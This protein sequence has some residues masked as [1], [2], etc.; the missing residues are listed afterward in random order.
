MRP[1]PPEVNLL[2]RLIGYLSPRAALKRRWARF[3]LGQIEMASGRYRG[4]AKD[5]LRNDWITT[6]LGSS[7]PN[8]WELEELRNR[9]RELNCNHPVAHGATDTLTQNVV[10]QGLTPQSKLRAENLGISPEEAKTL[11]R[12]AESIWSLWSAYAD[13]GDRLD[14]NEIQFLALRKIIE[15]GEIIAIPTFIKDNR[16]PL[17]RALEL[18]ESD[19]LLSPPGRVEIMQGVELGAER[20]EPVRYWLRKA[21]LVKRDYEMDQQIYVGIPARDARGRPMVLHVFPT[22]RPGQVRGIPY[23]APVLSYFKD[24]GDYLE[25]EVVAARVAACL[26]VFITK[27]DGYGGAVAG[28]TGT[29]TS[30]NRVQALEPGMIPYLNVG[31]DIKVVDPKGRG[32]ETFGGMLNGLLRIIGASLG[33]PYELLLKDFSQTNYSSA[34]AALLEGRRM[35]TQWRGWFARKFCQPIFELVLEEAYLRGL[36]GARDFYRD[37][38]ELCRVTWVGGGWGWVDPVKEVQ[39]SK[40]AIDYGLSTQA[41]EAAGQGRDWEEIFEQLQREKER[42]AELG[43]V[44]PVSGAPKMAVAGGPEANQEGDDNAQAE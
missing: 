16:R 30:G 24:L 36:F 28:A 5:R 20:R 17:G 41:E 21:P 43:L 34:R 26:A 37:R 44:F 27:T 32:G 7:T 14:F 11:R 10:G 18:I 2:D 1:R 42:A 4:S 8:A 22:Q 15:D 39:A 13:A 12:Q 29:D 19:R 3:G 38:D 9:S 33:L 25:A 6:Y 31:E 23:F 35:F 40:L